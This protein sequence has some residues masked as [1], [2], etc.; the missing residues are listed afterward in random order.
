MAETVFVAFYKGDKAKVD[1]AMSQFGTTEQFTLKFAGG[2][3]EQSGA[4]DG[5]STGIGEKMTYAF[6]D[7]HT[8]TW[9]E[10]FSGCVNTFNFVWQGTMFRL[11][12]LKSSCPADPIG[13]IIYESSAWSLKPAA[14]AIPD[15][16]YAGGLIARAT[17]DATFAKL[18]VAIS[19]DV[20]TFLDE[21]PARFAMRLQGG[22]M[23]VLVD[24]GGSGFQIGARATYAFPDDRTMTFQDNIGCLDTVG[25]S[26]QN[27]NLTLTVMTDSC[28]A[29]DMAELR[30]IFETTPFTPVP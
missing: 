25:I 14:S 2:R 30:V 17:A 18:G 3:M 16:E 5:Q 21:F 1:Q 27:S 24:T 8:I 15:G 19:A 22:H 26:S 9:Q 13:Q 28:G 11:K 20:Q 23:D 7:D 6:P 10:Q 4:V 29:T 12:L